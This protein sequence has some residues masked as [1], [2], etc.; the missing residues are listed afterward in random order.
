MTLL[1]STPEAYSLDTKPS[2]TLAHCAGQAAARCARGASWQCFPTAFGP[3]HKRT[4]PCF[5][6]GRERRIS[7]LLLASGAG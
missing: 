3:S 5:I 7:R 2:C 6:A 4:C 1:V